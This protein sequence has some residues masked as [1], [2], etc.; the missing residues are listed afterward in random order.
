MLLIFIKRVWLPYAFSVV[1]FALILAMVLSFTSGFGE[2]S[3]LPLLTFS[4]L[5]IAVPVT[6]IIAMPIAFYAWLVQ[7]RRGI[8]ISHLQAGIIGFALGTVLHTLLLMCFGA[9]AM[10]PQILL[11]TAMCG[12]GFGCSF[13]MLFSRCGGLVFVSRQDRVGGLQDSGTHES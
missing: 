3:G 6:L 11:F 7:Q 5:L 8:V 9:S 10:L 4:V 13:A 2:L 1:A 12:G